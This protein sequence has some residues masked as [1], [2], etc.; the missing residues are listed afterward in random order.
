MPTEPG[1][2]RRE[3]LEAFIADQ[4]A[5]WRPST[6]RNRYLALKRDFDWL[7]GEGLTEVSPMARTRPPRMPAETTP[8][9]REMSRSSRRARFSL[10]RRASSSRS[11]AVRPS[12]R[13]ASMSAWATQRRTAVSERPRS[14]AIAALDRSPDRQSLTAWALYWSGNDRLGRLA[15]YMTTSR[16]SRS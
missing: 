1:R 2:I 6:A 9:L 4:I 12:W 13:P 3:H 8:L 16:P 5:R 14:R 10:R 15:R 11:A 7:A